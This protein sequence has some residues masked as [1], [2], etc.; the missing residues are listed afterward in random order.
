LLNRVHAIFPD[1]DAVKHVR[2]RGGDYKV[3]SFRSPAEFDDTSEDANWRWHNRLT[4]VALAKR[5][6]RVGSDKTVRLAGQVLWALGMHDSKHDAELER[7]NQQ[8]RSQLLQAQKLTALGELTSTT[9]H[10]FN[11]VLTTIINYAKLGL[12]H[13]DDATRDKALQKILAAGQRAGKIT[14]SVLGMARNRKDNFE[15]TDLRCIVEETLVLLDRE[16]LKYRIQ[17]DR[18]LPEVPP[19]LAIGNQIQQVLLNLLINARQAMPRGGHLLVRLVHDEAAGMVDLTIRDT[20]HGIPPE[21]LSR[22]FDPFF[23]TKRGPD[24]SGKGGTGL[25]LSACHNIVE[26][27]AG[28]IRVESTV[29]RGTAFTVRL[30]MARPSA[31]DAGETRPVVSEPVM[32][33]P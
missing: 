21:E 26:S 24:R 14:N 30:P 25:G 15:P 7:E 32:R 29:G 10:E 16:L 12:R 5:W 31:F 17:V 13:R 6:N 20:G 4:H 19:V 27:H 28:R 22:I 33:T 2:K 3:I 23:T 8:L 9:T 11:N 18:D 1:K